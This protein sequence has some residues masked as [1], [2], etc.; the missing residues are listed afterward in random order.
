MPLA[1]LV[2]GNAA[3][4]VLA[5]ALVSKRHEH[6]PIAA[7]LT[8]MLGINLAQF[9][10]EGFVLAPLRATLGMAQPWTGWAWAASLLHNVT[11]A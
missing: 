2:V 8:L 6:R 5:W 7:L 10:L 4:I 3:A 11:A 1:I 9:L